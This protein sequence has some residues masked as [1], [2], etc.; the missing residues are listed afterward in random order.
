MILF[1]YWLVAILTAI[2]MMALAYKNGELDSLYSWFMIT[3]IAGAGG[4]LWPLLLLA[5]VFL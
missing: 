5:G 3:A 2:T 1:G 4:L